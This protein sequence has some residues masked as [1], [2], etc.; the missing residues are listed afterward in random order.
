M[1]FEYTEAITP[2]LVQLLEQTTLGT[3]GAMY[4]QLDVPERIYQNDY[5]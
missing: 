2:E 4:R 5:P 1:K 3:N